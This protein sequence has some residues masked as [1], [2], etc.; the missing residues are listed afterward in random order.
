MDTKRLQCCKSFHRGIMAPANWNWQT[1]TNGC[2]RAAKAVGSY[3][4]SLQAAGILPYDVEFT[5]H[6]FCDLIKMVSHLPYISV[7]QYTCQDYQCECEKEATYN[8]SS[9]LQEEVRFIKQQQGTFICLDCLKTE[10]RSK[11]E[12]NCRISHS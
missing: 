12:G 3:F 9:K 11:S 10:E 6:R 1:L 2:C 8:L 5:E 4:N 7:S